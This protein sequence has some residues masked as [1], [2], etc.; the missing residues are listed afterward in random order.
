VANATDIAATTENASRESTCCR[1]AFDRIASTM[2]GETLTAQ[3]Q[4]APDSG[5]FAIPR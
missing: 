4:K 5:A 1:A 2:A 3:T